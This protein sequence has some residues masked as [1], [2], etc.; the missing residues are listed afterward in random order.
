MVRVGLKANAL[1]TKCLL[2]ALVSYG[3]GIGVGPT[4]RKINVS[5]NQKLGQSHDS[6]PNA[7]TQYR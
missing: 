5:E 4:G 7:I 1:D 6:R 2:K 3:L